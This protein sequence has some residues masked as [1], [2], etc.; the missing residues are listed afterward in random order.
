MFRKTYPRVPLHPGFF[1]VRLL[2]ERATMPLGEIEC[3]G[4]ASVRTMQRTLAA[5]E[6]EGV[7]AVEVDP[8]D[9]RRRTVN[10]RA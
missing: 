3:S 1:L 10:L 5:M 6:A 9:R 7:I 2:E 8:T 4:L